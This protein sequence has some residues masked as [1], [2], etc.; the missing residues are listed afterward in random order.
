MLDGRKV[1]SWCIYILVLH[2]KHISDSL[3][4]LGLGISPSF[5][6]YTL[7]AVIFYGEV[8]PES[9]LRRNVEARV[10]KLV[11]MT[12]FLFHL[13]KNS[14]QYLTLV[15]N[16]VIFFLNSRCHH[17]QSKSFCGSL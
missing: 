1:N 5:L 16:P 4:E 10:W 2:P 9:Y 11:D 15:I 7:K 8:Y 6:L 14:A 13:E 17:E 12:F 3:T